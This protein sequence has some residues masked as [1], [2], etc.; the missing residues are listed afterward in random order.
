MGVLSV[1]FIKPSDMPETYYNYLKSITF[2][3]IDLVN[4]SQTMV[5][6]VNTI[7][8][9]SDDTNIEKIDR[10]LQLVPPYSSI[11]TS[12]IGMII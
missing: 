6:G 9:S 5:N 7:V 3:G 1:Y 8:L 10:A 2:Y 4:K 12:I 11:F